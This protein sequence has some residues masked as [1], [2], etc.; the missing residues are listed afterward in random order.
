MANKKNKNNRRNNTHKSVYVKKKL[1]PRNIEKQHNTEGQQSDNTEEQQS[2]NEEEEVAMFEGSRVINLEKLQQYTDNLIAHATHCDGSITLTGET[3]DGLASVLSCHC[4]TCQDTITFETSKKVK[5]PRGYRRWEC[6]LG[7]VWGQMSTGGGHTQL[8]ESMSVVGIPV[9]TKA[10]FVHTERDIGELWMRELQELMRQAG[11]EERR[12]AIE[13][14]S[15]HED[16]PAITVIVDGGWSKRAHKHSY[17]AKSGVGIILARR[18]ERCY[19]WVFAIS[20]VM[21]V[22]GRSHTKSA[23]KTG[24]NPLLRWKLIYFWMVFWKLKEFTGCDTPDLLGMEIVPF[25]LP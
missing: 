18:Q 22:P 20:T 11:R 8:E 10:S 2:D 23:T 21:H 19:T 7:A 15:F 4:S 12:I 1:P 5:G 16:V 25:I 14:N 24:H 13:K 3:R 6:N 9:M 17:N